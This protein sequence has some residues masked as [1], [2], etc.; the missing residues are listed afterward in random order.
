ERKRFSIAL[1][2]AAVSPLRG[3]RC[4]FARCS[5]RQRSSRATTALEIAA[6]IRSNDLRSTI[7][8][9]EYDHDQTLQTVAHPPRSHYRPSSALVRPSPTRML[10]WVTAMRLYCES[11]LPRRSQAL[12]REQ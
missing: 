3:W 12:R 4:N 5:K 9:P 6:D 8:R 2:P 1:R 10:E 7:S 11:K